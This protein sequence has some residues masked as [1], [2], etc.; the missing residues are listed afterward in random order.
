MRD[1]ELA[2][3][4][5]RRDLGDGLMLRWST[6]A[7]TEA[8]AHLHSMV[9]RDQ[10]DAPPNARIAARMRLLMR[11]DFPGMGAGDFAVVE[12]T[13]HAEHPIVA[14]ACLWR[15]T[16]EYEGIPLGVGRPEYVA[17]AAAYRNRGLIRAI[18]TLLHARSAAEGHQLQA[19]TG[20]NH[21][22]RQ[23][24]YEYALDLEGKRVVTVTQIPPLSPGAEE[25]HLMR[26]ATVE[27]IPQIMALHA[28]R[29]ADSLLW[30]VAP[31]GYWRYQIVE[32]AEIG[33][34]N[35]AGGLLMIADAA[36]NSIGYL[37][38]SLRRGGPNLDVY[39]FETLPGINLRAVTL[40]ML[41]RLAAYGQAI[42]NSAPD[43]PLQT[44]TF[45]LGRAHPVYI[46]L[47]SDLAPVHDPPYAWYI[48]A[49]DLLGLLWLIAPA[50][51]RR[52]AASLLAGYSGALKLDWYRGGAR[53][54]FDLGKLVAVEPWRPP[55]YGE[56]A[57]AGCPA[58]TFLQLLCGYRSLDELRA[59]FPDVWAHGEAQLLLAILFPKR[60]SYVLE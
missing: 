5:Y 15:H 21:Y 49:P 48:R 59:I 9:H 18:F 26:P 31:A 46:A 19:I 28:Q 58:L 7:D 20:I 25:A 35:K 32:L 44:L 36:G 57:D 39:A 38:A 43:A 45:Q 22:Y 12:D 51:E 40:A 42:P 55:A 29:R 60:P 37:H 2:R 47:G 23:F 1:D 16:W 6:P 54:A 17:T 34:P 24:G 3:P 30:S 52:L 4:V 41:R 11:G 14:C 50:L 56:E 53:L 8:I 27:D 33:S 10:P 13:A